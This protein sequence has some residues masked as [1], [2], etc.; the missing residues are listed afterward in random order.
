MPSAVN[1]RY[2]NSI[3][4]GNPY[5]ENER[6]SPSYSGFHTQLDCKL[7]YGNKNQTQL[8]LVQYIKF[9]AYKQ[10]RNDEKYSEIGITVKIHTTHDDV[11][12]QEAEDGRRCQMIGSGKKKWGE[13]RDVVQPLP[14]CFITEQ[15]TLNASLYG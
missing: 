4:D 9:L 1:L 6:H 13:T 12:L 10:N 11:R 5:I 14:A 15:S 8:T 7:T 3:R 2:Y